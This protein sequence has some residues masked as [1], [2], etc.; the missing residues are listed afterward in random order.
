M[1]GGQEAPP[2]QA[3]AIRGMIDTEEGRSSIQNQLLTRVALE[4]MEEIASQPEDESEDAP[5]RGRRRGRRR[6][7]ATEDSEA[8]QAATDSSDEPEASDDSSGD[9]ASEE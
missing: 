3:E 6:A 4:R 8:P 1:T 5:A 7:A 2:E 9:E